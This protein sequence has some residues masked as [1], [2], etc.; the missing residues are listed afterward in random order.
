M[1]ELDVE[2]YELCFIGQCEGDCTKVL[3]DS[4]TCG[5]ACIAEGSAATACEIFC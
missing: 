5:D 4:V 2:I 1:P 3:T